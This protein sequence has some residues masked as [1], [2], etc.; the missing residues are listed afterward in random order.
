M[1][2]APFELP[3]MAGS[4]EERAEQTGEHQGCVRMDCQPKG[5]LSGGRR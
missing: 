5:R 2:P 3:Q 4:G 1:P